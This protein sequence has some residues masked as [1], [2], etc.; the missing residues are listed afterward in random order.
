MNPLAELKQLLAARAGRR[1]GTVLSVA[2]GRAEVA[3]AAGAQTVQ[4]GSV[5]AAADDRVVI[6]QGVVIGKLTV[7]SPPVYTL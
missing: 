4:L 6:E 7:E 2:A 3:T 5:A 1:T